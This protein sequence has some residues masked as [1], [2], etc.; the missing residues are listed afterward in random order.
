MSS[1]S[2]QTDPD[3]T[4]DAKGKARRRAAL[5][6]GTCIGRYLLLEPIGTG[7]MG[8]VYKAIDPQLNRP[9]ALKLL[10]ADEEST[11]AQRD[12]L[13]REAQALARLQHPNVVAVFDVGTFGGDVFIAMELVE[14]R[15]L[16]AWLADA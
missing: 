12:R 6:R 7:G 4:V 5:A 1:E 2:S 9:I 10:R 16:R 8:V 14:G 13:L 15:T 11:E 3:H